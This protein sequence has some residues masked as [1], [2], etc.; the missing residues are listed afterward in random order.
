M[1]LLFCNDAHVKP[2]P[3]NAATLKKW[4]TGSGRAKKPEMIR[5]ADMHWP[6]YCMAFNRPADDNE[7][8]ALLLLAWA[9]EE[10]GREG[11]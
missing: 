4:A 2:V 6:D 11:E 8:D 7:A 5:A 1:I 3:V 10:F 9:R